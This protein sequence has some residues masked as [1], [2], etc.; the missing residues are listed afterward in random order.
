MQ[1]AMRDLTTGESSSR[2]KLGRLA[3]DDAPGAI[4]PEEVGAELTANGATDVQIITDDDADVVER[5]G[6]G[7]DNDTF[8]VH[9]A[10]ADWTEDGKSWIAFYGYW[11]YKAGFIGSGDP[12]DA[13]AMK[14]SGF[15]KDCWYNASEGVRTTDSEGHRTSGYTS[16]YSDGHAATI[17]NVNDDTQSFTL[18]TGHGFAWIEMRRDKSGC[19]ADKEG[20]FWHEHNQNGNGGWSGGIDLW[21]FNLSYD[22]SGG[23]S[24]RKSTRLSTYNG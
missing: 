14:V 9:K 8:K 11:D 22:G 6:G 10:W 16:K 24:L 20:K 17:W 4:T 21:V 23:Q 1:E 5:T 18:K 15:N 3:L 19:A 13:A 7:L 12:Y 2:G